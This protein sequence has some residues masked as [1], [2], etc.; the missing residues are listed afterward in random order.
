MA[1]WAGDKRTGHA[2]DGV[3]DGWSGTA[4]LRF[5]LDDLANEPELTPLNV[6]SLAHLTTWKEEGLWEADKATIE[7][8]ARELDRVKNSRHHSGALRDEIAA[9]DRKVTRVL[10]A[11]G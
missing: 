11:R 6:P 1:W 9:I 10:D 7:R 2:H 5:L 3:L 8:L 4:T